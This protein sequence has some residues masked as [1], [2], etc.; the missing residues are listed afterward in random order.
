MRY[1]AYAA[2]NPWG[3]TGLEWETP[4]PPPTENFPET[5]TVSGRPY[6]YLTARDREA[7]IG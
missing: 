5:P 7:A 3:A 6:D 4:S 1:G 2:D